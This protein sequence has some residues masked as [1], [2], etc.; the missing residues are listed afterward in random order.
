MT[1]RWLVGVLILGLG[2]AG[3]W[4]QGAPDSTAAKYRPLL[5]ALRDTVG[6]VAARAN[7][8]RRDLKTAGE[9]TVLARAARL[10]EACRD[11][12]GALTAA[13]PQ[14]AAARLT[15]QQASA[16]DTL[17]TVIGQ[18][19]AGLQRDCERGLGTTG[20]GSRADSLRAW[21]P[22]RTG[23]LAQAVTA[24][25]GASARFARRIGVDLTRP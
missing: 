24:Y 18:L 6:R 20:P 13:R 10:E 14:F 15:P 19:V 3:G 11:A 16:R 1:A 7:D 4:A 22:H 9:T 21:G 23:S 17:V 2:P 12:R 5:I 25:Q 8:F